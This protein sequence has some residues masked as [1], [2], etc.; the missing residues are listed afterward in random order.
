MV[1]ASLNPFN[2]NK[3]YI[4]TFITPLIKIDISNN[5]SVDLSA[6]PLKSY[7]DGSLNTINNIL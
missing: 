3:Q 4:F 1:D 2:T 5:I 7:G 6:Y